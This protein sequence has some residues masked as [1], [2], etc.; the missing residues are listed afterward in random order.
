MPGTET[1]P[2]LGLPFWAG[3]QAA[4]WLVENEIARAFEALHRA[5]VLDRDLTAPPGTCDDGAAYLVGGSATGLW[6]TH[7]GE[8]AVAK[9]TDAVNGWIFLPVATEGKLLFVEDEAVLLQYLSAAWS[10]FTGGG[11]GAAYDFGFVFEA[12][13]GAD[14]VVGRVRIGRNITIPANMTGSTGGVGVNPTATFD[15][16]VQDDGVS[17][18]TISVSTGGTLTFTTDS[19]TSKAVAAGSEI[20]FVAPTTPDTTVEA[21]SAVI[22]ATED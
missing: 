19:G 1:S 20:T 15:I 12:T 13:P 10:A 4:P 11:S 14:A 6:A 16:D 9:G 8:L 22:L 18:G 5:S 7:D 2:V 21:M 17:I 3:P